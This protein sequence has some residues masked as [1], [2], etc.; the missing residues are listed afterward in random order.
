MY[1]VCSFPKIYFLQ[2]VL[3]FF[4]LFLKCDDDEYDDDNY[5][6]DDNDDVYDYVNP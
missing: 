4:Y 3:L 1:N 5:E 6:Y 2:K